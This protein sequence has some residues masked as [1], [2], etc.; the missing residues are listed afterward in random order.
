LGASDS[1]Y[2]GGLCFLVRRVDPKPLNGTL[3]S[4]VEVNGTKTLL[5]PEIVSGPSWLDYLICFQYYDIYVLSVVA[6]DNTSSPRS[7][8]NCIE[9][10]GI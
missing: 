9:T 1:D 7:G 6:Q 5:Q 2:S 10:A 4:Y 3:C 8:K